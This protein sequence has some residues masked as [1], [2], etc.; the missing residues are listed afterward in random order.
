MKS[1][2]RTLGL[3]SVVGLALVAAVVFAAD[4]GKPAAP[5]T[6][7]IDGPPPATAP[8]AEVSSEAAAVLKDLGAAYA[9]L[10]T[11]DLV[12]SMA[13]TRQELQRLLSLLEMSQARPRID[14]EYALADAPLALAKIVTGEVNGKLVVLPTK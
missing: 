2:I 6:A 13:G 3:V 12:G 8:A 9:K 1:F 4:P 11:L 10:K 14:G 7:P 5:A